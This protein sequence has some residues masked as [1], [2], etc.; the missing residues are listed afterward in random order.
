MTYDEIVNNSALLSYR[1][2]QPGLAH[3]PKDARRVA[4]ISGSPLSFLRVGH[5]EQTP[6]PLFGLAALSFVPF[7]SRN[8]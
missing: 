5:Q 2:W 7:C 1:C 8:A 4:V 3:L 6:L